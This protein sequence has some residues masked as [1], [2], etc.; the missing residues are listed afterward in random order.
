MTNALLLVALVVSGLGAWLSRRWR[1]PGQAM[2]VL[3]VLGL[4]GFLALQLRQN[5]FPPEAKAPGR[6]EMAVSACLANFILRDLAGRSGDV[7]LL[8]PKRQYM[9]AETEQSYEQGFTLPLRHA[10]GNLHLKALHLEAAK[11]TAGYDLSAFKQ[12]IAQAQDALAIISYAGAPTGIETLLAQQPNHTLIY[13]FDADGTTNWLA[14]LKQG[15]ISAVVLPRPGVSPHEREAARGMP[16]DI[17]ERFYLLAT[18]ESADQ[19]VA[20]LSKR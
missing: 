5:V 13:V 3:G 7:V 14:G 10:H 16:Q 1:L 9:D 20:Q 8:F 6:G 11:G 15:L 12:A 4:L 19:T 18:P 2:I 17:F